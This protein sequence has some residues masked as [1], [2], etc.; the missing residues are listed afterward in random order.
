MSF[1]VTKTII[2]R[3]HSK[4]KFTGILIML[5]ILPLLLLLLLFG[6][7]MVVFIALVSPFMKKK[8]QEAAASPSNEV[9]LLAHDNITLIL[10][11][12]EADAALMEAKEAW[13]ATVEPDAGSLYRARANPQ[14]LSLH[15]KLMTNFIKQTATGAFLQI[16]GMGQPG[17]NAE[18]QSRLVFLDFATLQVS[19]MSD[20]GP[21]LLSEDREDAW[22]L[23]GDNY[24]NQLSI[25]IRDHGV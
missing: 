14:I 10:T 18:I 3:A 1:T 12:D 21:Y 25:S 23:R 9:V 22:K 24:N 11:G 17:G 19:A 5:L 16:V 13:A 8:P 20:V 7:I 4:G 6:V 15:D 2:A